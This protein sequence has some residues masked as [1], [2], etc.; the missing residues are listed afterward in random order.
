MILSSVFALKVLEKP[1]HALCRLSH[2]TQ[3]FS[4]FGGEGGGVSFA[5]FFGFVLSVFC[6]SHDPFGCGETFR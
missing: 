6:C 3:K 4:F 1:I 5:F 2:F